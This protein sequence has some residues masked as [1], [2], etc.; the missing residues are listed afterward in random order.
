MIHGA[1]IKQRIAELAPAFE[2]QLTAL[3]GIPSVSMGMKA[4]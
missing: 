1:R 3:C 4:V 2:E